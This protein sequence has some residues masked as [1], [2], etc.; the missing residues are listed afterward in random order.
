ME[1]KVTT[2]KSDFDFANY[3]NNALRH[4]LGSARIAALLEKNYDGVVEES[5][6]LS[7]LFH[8]R[9]TILTGPAEFGGAIKGYALIG[10]LEYHQAAKLAEL[11]G[12]GRLEEV[13]REFMAARELD[14]KYINDLDDGMVALW[15]AYRSNA[16]IAPTSG[17]F[18]LTAYETIQKLRALT[19]NIGGREIPLFNKDE[20][21]ARAWVP[22]NDLHIMPHEKLAFIEFTAATINCDVRYWNVRETRDHYALLDA[23]YNNDYFCP[24]NPKTEQE[25]AALLQEVL[26]GEVNGKPIFNEEYES[27]RLALVGDITRQESNLL[28][29]L[30]RFGLE[31]KYGEDGVE[32]TATEPVAAGRY[33]LMLARLEH[34]E[35]LLETSGGADIHDQTFNQ[36]SIGATLAG[37]AEVD[38]VIL[39]AMRGELKLTS[40]NLE[41]LS[42]QYPN[43]S[44]KIRSGKNN[45]K[46]RLYATPDACNVTLCKQLDISGDEPT[47]FGLSPANGLGTITPGQE[48]AGVL[49][50]CKETSM[51]SHY[52]V[53]TKPWMAIGQALIFLHE[54][55]MKRA[56]PRFPEEAGAA[57]LAGFLREQFKAGEITVDD[58]AFAL[59]NNGFDKEVFEEMLVTQH[60]A[61]RCNPWA[62][63][64]RLEEAHGVNEP[65]FVAQLES[66]FGRNFDELAPAIKNIESD[67]SLTFYSTGYNGTRQI[68]MALQTAIRRNENEIVSEA[69]AA[70]EDKPLTGGNGSLFYSFREMCIKW[71]AL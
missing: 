41:L 63:L 51:Q 11:Q 37:A 29:S 19:I 6:L 59:R 7:N 10:F 24:T 21:A 30:K 45:V 50:G 18:G 66:A 26:S 40:G 44:A 38:R 71:A 46:M 1:I 15:D 14:A 49:S 55:Q 31:I 56:E 33:G 61:E 68:A 28:K 16:I 47:T 12:S 8:K 32:I 62:M 4:A 70:P 53:A 34:W 43:I 2:A 69:A 5:D 35:Y 27:L 17:S 39:L 64:Y 57:S 13:K 60:G 58:I 42:S 22:V 9:T 3:A 25:F 54:V 20:A 23:I 36:P 52:L 65:K 67:S 48:S